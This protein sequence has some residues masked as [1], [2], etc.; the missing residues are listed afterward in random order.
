M[1]QVLEQAEKAGIT[2]NA[3][4]SATEDLNLMAGVQ[5]WERSVQGAGV[6]PQL[7]LRA[8]VPKLQGLFAKALPTLG[9][10]VSDPKVIEELQAQKQ[11]NEE[12][13]DRF[14][15]LQVKC[16][17][18]LREKTDVTAQLDAARSAPESSEDP[19]MLK[20]TI[21]ALDAGRGR[22]GGAEC[23][24]REDEAVPLDAHAAHQEE[25]RRPAAAGAAQGERHRARWRRLKRRHHL[26]PPSGHLRP[27]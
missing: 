1:K 26:R 9:A 15:K 7:K 10:T 11:A 2:L 21:M 14:Q 22:A 4:L 5:A 6:A 12:L 24:A 3:D 27:P 18:I 8:G 13:T 19:A 25:R 16:T 20:A 23:Q 17:Q